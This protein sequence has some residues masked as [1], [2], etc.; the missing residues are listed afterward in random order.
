MNDLEKDTIQLSP[1]LSRV[2]RRHFDKDYSLSD[3]SGIIRRYINKEDSLNAIFGRYHRYFERAISKYSGDRN[4]ERLINTNA[5]RQKIRNLMRDLKL[6]S[7]SD[8]DVLRRFKEDES[9]QRPIVNVG[10]KTIILFK[11]E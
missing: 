9:M 8:F 6:L 1:A 3:V 11:E 10:G 7:H 4:P 2:F 5:W